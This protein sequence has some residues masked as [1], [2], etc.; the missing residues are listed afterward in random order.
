MA[1]VFSP[2]QLGSQHSPAPAVTSSSASNSTSMHT[3]S[4]ALQSKVLRD[5]AASGIAVAIANVATNPIEVSGWHGWVVVLQQTA[6]LYNRRQPHPGL[7]HGTTAS[8]VFACL[9][10]GWVFRK[11]VAD[12]VHAPLITPTWVQKLG[13]HSS[14]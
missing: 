14:T 6:V 12:V 13:H 2:G 11:V 5:F 10:H 1:H 8:W 3:L 9:L 7:C 4:S